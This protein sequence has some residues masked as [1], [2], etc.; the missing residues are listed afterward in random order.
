MTLKILQE[1]TMV[2]QIV[3]IMGEIQTLMEIIVI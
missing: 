3:T 2:T 1:I